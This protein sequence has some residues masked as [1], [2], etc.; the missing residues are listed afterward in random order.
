M[1]SAYSWRDYNFQSP[2]H[3]GR[4]RERSLINTKDRHRGFPRGVGVSYGLECAHL[5]GGSPRQRFKHGLRRDVRIYEC[6]SI[7]DRDKGKNGSYEL[8]REPGHRRKLYGM[9]KIAGANGLRWQL[10]AVRQ[11]VE[12]IEARPRPGRAVTLVDGTQFLRR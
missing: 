5:I 12:G 8:F 11:H 1:R 2:A 4:V 3:R 7:R 10:R 9:D 6:G